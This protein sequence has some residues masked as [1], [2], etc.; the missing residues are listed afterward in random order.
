M[1][2][3]PAPQIRYSRMPSPPRLMGAP[4]PAAT[5]R[6]DGGSNSSPGLMP[7]ASQI[8]SKVAT[9]ACTVSRSKRLMKDLLTPTFC[10]TSSINMP[11]AWRN[12]RK[13]L[14]TLNG[15]VLPDDPVAV[16]A[17]GISIFLLGIGRSL[18]FQ[19]D[20]LIFTYQEPS[21][22]YITPYKQ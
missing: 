5:K 12:A 1:C 16:P 19:L 7:M 18:S 15:S 11:L 14:P 17:A 6:V 22:K 3:L 20:N 8:R 13:R 10:A 9:E 2:S 4:C 21:Q